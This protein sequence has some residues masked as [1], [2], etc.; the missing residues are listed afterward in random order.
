MASNGGLFIVDTVE[1]YLYTLC[2][3]SLRWLKAQFKQLGLSRRPNPPNSY[4]R[5][6]IR[7]YSNFT[8]E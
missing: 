6:L 4:I 3:C 8:Y 7:V 5:S 2:Y 1:F